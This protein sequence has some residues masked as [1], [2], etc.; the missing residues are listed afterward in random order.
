MGQWGE[1]FGQTGA[2]AA[3]NL[4]FDHATTGVSL[5]PLHRAAPCES[6]H[7]GGTFKGT[8]RV[9]STCHAGPGSRALVWNKSANHIP[10]KNIECSV[11]HTSGGLV[12]Y[13]GL[14]LVEQFPRLLLAELRG[15]LKGHQGTRLTRLSG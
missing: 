3:Q 7:T 2:G 14:R 15:L 10:A 12:R 11:C 1:A 13:W 4:S 8:P 9:C 6:C 5:D